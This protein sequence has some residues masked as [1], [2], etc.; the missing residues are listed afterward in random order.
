ARLSG[1]EMQEAVAANNMQLVAIPPSTPDRAAVWYHGDTHVLTADGDVERLSL[2]LNGRA[3]R[4][5]AM[6][7]AAAIQLPENAAAADIALYKSPYRLA[8]NIKMKVEK[9]R[10]YTF[11]KFVAASR[12]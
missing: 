3:E 10:T 12:E 2:F 11:G 7:E 1:D 9:N 5:L 6:A 8:L 4:G